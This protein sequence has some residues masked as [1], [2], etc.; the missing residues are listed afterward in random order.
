M[1]NSLQNFKAE[2]FK[3]LAHP[4]R[5]KILEAVRESEKSVSELQ[6]ILNLD[7]SSVSQQL[8]V[9]R[10]KN[11]LSSRKSGTTVYYSARDPL[12]YDLL[13][14]ARNIFNNH[15]IDTKDLLTQLETP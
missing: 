1:P 4:I 5:I 6:V 10:T 12:I 15:L 3:A 9:L 13:D 14:V 2:F 8:S 11:L 7:Q